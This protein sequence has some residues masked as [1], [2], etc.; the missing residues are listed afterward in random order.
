VGLSDAPETD[1]LTVG[2]MAADV[3]ATYDGPADVIG[4]SLGAA[5][6]LE[7]ALEQPER[8]RSL[9]LI[10]PFVVASSR[11]LAVADA[12]QRVASEAGPETLAAA[13]LPWFFSDDLLTDEAARGRTLRGLAQTVSRVPASTLARMVAGMTAWSGTRQGDLGAI[14]VPTL[15]VVAGGDLLA[16]AAETIAQAIPN[17]KTVVIDEAAH[18]VALEA[19]EAVSEAI[20]A[21]LAGRA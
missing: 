13:L 16:P 5:I 1:I 7:L 17:A 2:Q 11:L 9:T 10:T 12:W 20:S 19:P 6:A 4:A 14:S 3:A 18:A 15:V 21:H 8:V